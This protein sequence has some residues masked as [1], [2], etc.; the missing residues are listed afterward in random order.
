MLIY[1]GRDDKKALPTK[2]T[3]AVISASRIQCGNNDHMTIRKKGRMDWSLFYC[4]SG[5]MYFEDTILEAGQIWIYAPDV[6]QKY[7]VYRRDK[8]I[9]RYLHFTGSDMENLLDTLGIHTSKALDVN[10]YGISEIM[11]NIQNNLADDSP[12][13]RLN[14]EYT[15]LQLLSK[16]AK[17]DAQPSGMHMM[18]QVT[19]NMEHSFVAAYD[20]AYYAGM[21]KISVSRFNHLF[22]ECVGVSPYAYYVNLRITNACRLLE[23][24]DLKMKEIAEKC[25]YENA[26]YFGQA[27]KKT[28]GMTPS[29]YRRKNKTKK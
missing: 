19:D 22:R 14:A 10:K 3:A 6:S 23:D 21:L 11:E 25:G 17:C 26:L 8:T 7:M 28:I 27:F 9:Y 29:M 5:R 15:V 13:A 16:L 20:A 4:E 2:H 1:D 24:T 12:L 18:Q